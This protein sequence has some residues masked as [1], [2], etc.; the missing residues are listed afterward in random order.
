MFSRLLER[1][2]HLQ[3]LGTRPRTE[4]LAGLT[5]F[6]GMVY[7][8]FVNPSILAQAGID[9]GAAFVATCLAALIGSLA[10][11]LL[12]NYPIALAPGMGLNAYFTFGV[13]KGMGHSWETAL[14]AVFLSGCI[15]LLLSVLRVREWI[16]DAIP[17]GLK[18]AISAGIGLFL[19]VIALK[20]AGLVVAHPQTLVTLGDLGDP[21]VLLAA[22]GFIL[23]VALERRGLRGA[24][25]VAILAVT[26][27]GVAL[28]LTPAQ[29]VFALPPSLAPTFLKLDI[30]GALDIGLLTIVF[31]FLFVDLFD[32]AGTLVGVAH[33]A[34]LLDEDGRMPRI[35]RAFVADSAATIAGATLG[36]STTT[37]YIESALGVQAGGRSGLTAVTVAALFGV[38]LFLSPLAATVPAYATA[39]ALLYIACLMARGL[40]ELDWDEVTESAPAVVTALAMPMTFSIATGIGFGF[41]SYV[42]IKLLSGRGRDLNVG[43]C[44]ISGLFIFKFTWF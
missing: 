36:T 30:A 12:A 37:S 2:F 38:C 29:G 33:R 34:G 9:P 1:L 43:V 42:G 10:M 25:V 14:G 5:T 23:M 6:L 3:E 41:V 28:G 18:V 35:G 15:F 7:I 11:G 20:N 31:A 44:V 13:V 8:A 24:I 22:V 40:A 17:H 4:V 32:T 27:A 21:R 16:V 19:G 26:A 39:P